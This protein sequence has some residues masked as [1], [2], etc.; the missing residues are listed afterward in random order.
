MNGAVTSRKHECTIG[1]KLAP[2]LNF[3]NSRRGL[4]LWSRLVFCFLAAMIGTL[5]FGILSDESFSPMGFFL[6]LLFGAAWSV[7]AL[8]GPFLFIERLRPLPQLIF[9]TLTILSAVA[10]F[11]ASAVAVNVPFDDSLFF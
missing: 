7:A 3:L 10:F 2:L 8:F 11:T 9:W 4:P 6:G 5:D 1:G